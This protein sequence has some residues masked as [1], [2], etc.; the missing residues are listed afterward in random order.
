MASC[1]VYFYKRVFGVSFSLPQGSVRITLARN[2]AR[3]VEAAKLRFARR[4]GVEHWNLRADSFDLVELGEARSGRAAYD[5]RELSRIGEQRQ[6]NP[7]T[8][9][10]AAP[11]QGR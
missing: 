8:L 4:H 1:V 7:E 5:D 3:A 6:R 9:I 10:N 2:E 11:S